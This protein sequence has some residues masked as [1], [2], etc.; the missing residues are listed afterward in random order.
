MHM[1]TTR[2]M[3][4]LGSMALL[5]DLRAPTAAHALVQAS[6]VWMRR[7]PASA[8][9]DVFCTV[10]I[11]QPIHTVRTRLML[12]EELSLPRLQQ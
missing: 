1:R 8:M 9:T 5:P 2:T 11:S 3:Q 4:P 6:G 12:G 7:K 10:A